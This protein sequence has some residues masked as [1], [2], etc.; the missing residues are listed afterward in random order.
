MNMC[1]CFALNLTFGPTVAEGP[2]HRGGTHAC[3]VEAPSFNLSHQVGSD[4]KDL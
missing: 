3:Q 2:P 4:V 1:S